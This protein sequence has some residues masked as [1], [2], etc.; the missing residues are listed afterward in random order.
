MFGRSV[1]IFRLF[2][3]EVRLDLSW[4]VIAVLITWSLATSA[5][6]LI[7]PDLGRS[8][9]WWMGVA[10]MLGLFACIVL[11]ELGHAIVARRCGVPMRGITL[12]IFG[13]VAHMEKE[14]P[15]AKAEFLTAIGGPVVTMLLAGGFYLGTR[16]ASA[17]EAP[18]AMRAVLAYLAWINALLLL[19]NLVPAFPLDGGRVLRAALWSWKRDLRRATRI[20]A[21]LGAGFG[22]ALIALGVFSFLVGNLVG[23]L[24]W[25]LLGFFIRN[26]ADMSYQ[27]VLLRQALSGEPLRRF[28]HTD[29]ITIPPSLPIRDAVEQYV[30]HHY[31]K[32][33]PVVDDGRLLGCITVDQIKSVPREE[34]DQRSVRDVYAPCSPENAIAPDEDAVDALARMRRTGSSR[35]LVVDHDD[36]LVGIISLRDLLRFLSL[37]IELE[38]DAPVSDAWSRREPRHA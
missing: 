26:A 22:Y 3:F 38:G 8:T 35:L 23:G 30:Y 2:G 20:A 11:H 34:W 7:A 36:R 15:T 31:H 14:P 27:Q 12:F 25:L 17:T 28:M 29:P 19:F 37:K 33:F 9:Y 18:L 10:G 21:A 32:M 24:W 6:P 1:P 4:L 13:G 16:V 5:F